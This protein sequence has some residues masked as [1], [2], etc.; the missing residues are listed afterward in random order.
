MKKVLF[1][2][3]CLFFYSSFA[4]A[5]C[6][7]TVTEN[8]SG[9]LNIA[10]DDNDTYVINEGVTVHNTSG[11][12][13][14]DVQNHSGVTITNNGT[15][16]SNY[17]QGLLLNGSS[18]T[19]INNNGTIH[20][21]TSTI[22]L[23]SHA[24][25]ITINNTGTISSDNHG[26]ISNYAAGVS[27]DI[28]I[29]NSGTIK[30]DGGINGSGV[31]NS[32]W[33]GVIGLEGCTSSSA[34]CS[35]DTDATYTIT[36]SGTIEQTTYGYYAVR[37][38]N[39][40][41]AS[42][43]NTGTI[44][45]G[46][47][48]A[49]T[50]AG[51]G[52]RAI[53]M[54]ILVMKCVNTAKFNNCGD[55]DAG[56]GDKTTTIKIGD[57]AVF[58][59]GIDLNG[60]KANIVIDT[61]IKR[62][63]S[64]RIFDYVEEGTDNL[65]ITN[66]ST[67]T[68][69]SISEEVLTFSTGDTNV[70]GNV[71]Q[72]K[73]ALTGGTIHQHTGQGDSGTNKAEYYNAG[74]D[75][76]LTILGEKLEVE[77]NNQKYRAENTLT[78]IR[79]LFGAANYLGGQW[80]DNCTTIDPEKTNT[81]LNE[82]C[83]NRFVKLFHSYQKRDGVY[84]GTSSGIIGM[85]SPIEWK[86]YPIIS[87]LFV[88]YSNQSGDFNNGE[89]LGGDNF[90]LGLKNTYERRGF[91]ASFTPMIGVN[92]LEVK[93]Y[94]TDKIE[95]KATDFLSEFA[96]LNGKINKKIGTGEDNY[97]NISVEGT[98]GLQRFPEYLSKFTD[99]DLSVD[100][101]IE[102]LLSGGFEVSYLEEIP[103]NFVIKP[104]MGV[105]LNRNLNNTIN[106]TARNKNADVSNDHQETWSGYHAGVSLTKQVKDMNIDLDLM[107]GNEDGLINQIASISLTKSFGQSETTIPTTKSDKDIRIVSTISDKD[108]LEF[109]DLKKIKEFL[110]AK[111]EQ[112]KIEN[113]KLKMLSAKVIQENKASK[114]LI[115]ELLKENEKIKLEK[116]IFKN[117][118]LEKENKEIK[119]KLQKA[120][121]EDGVNKFLLLL[122]ITILVLFAY[123]ISSFI[124]SIFK[125]YVRKV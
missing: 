13:Y 20:G 88:G 112:L 18:D 43:T 3:L 1:I 50:V 39:H 66:N 118:I 47:E 95:I 44:I 115:V 99:G 93:D 80:P 48:T 122:F 33:V 27:G 61:D 119:D 14:F 40:S 51:A 7:T 11:N 120:T 15:L 59:N 49:V 102:Q 83:N 116:E 76:V 19:T 64:I 96:A 60:T 25:D 84:D 5:A 71:S 97:L 117:K 35:A 23:K 56:N 75:G 87:N 21:N 110:K 41:G 101:S 4:W 36:N 31:H 57:G 109:G 72:T 113:E 67:G 79:G 37:V 70:Y 114:Q 90:V 58:T 81:E 65:T 32:R 38:G 69:Y 89:Y 24:G 42:I 17:H 98:F 52:T 124:V 34:N 29:I 125:A 74:A 92:N 6:N 26:T 63:Y 100:E 86:G 108:L 28:S 12:S 55:P 62:D 73:E 107:Y 94:D 16:K 45:G 9:N 10:C 105:S 103:G 54:D 22:M 53:G 123:G 91:K 77:K 2:I 82:T 30:G 85:L 106:I 104:Y 68:T 78:K 46:P 111:N 121:S 8:T